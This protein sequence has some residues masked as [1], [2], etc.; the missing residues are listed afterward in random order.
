MTEI[1]RARTRDRQQAILIAI[2]VF[3]RQNG[4][5]PSVRELQA[6][7]EV[8]SVSV[9]NYHLRRLRTAGL[10]DYVDNTPRTVRLVRNA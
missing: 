2:R 7:C 5:A 4:Y 1:E 10:I 6:M 8:S 9:V 3:W